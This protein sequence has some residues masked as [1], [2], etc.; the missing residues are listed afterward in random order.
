MTE[1]K[2]CPRFLYNIIIVLLSATLLPTISYLL[3]EGVIMYVVLVGILISRGKYVFYGSTLWLLIYIVILLSDLANPNRPSIY[4]LHSISFSFGFMFVWLSLLKILDAKQCCHLIKWIIIFI[5]IT[6]ISSFFIGLFRPNL[7]REISVYGDVLTSAIKSERNFYNLL[8]LMSYGF[9]HAVP[10]VIPALIALGKEQPSKYNVFNLIAVI[11]VLTLYI[12]GVSTAAFIG[13]FILIL[14][15]LINKKPNNRKLFWRVVFFTFIYVLLGDL[16]ITWV[17]EL[18]QPLFTNFLIGNKINS[19][20]D[21][22]N[23]MSDD[24]EL[25]YRQELH[26]LSW[27]TFVSNPFWGCNDWSI[28]KIGGHSFL[29]D[30]LAYRGLLGFLPFIILI[31]V[32]V[33]TQMMYINKSLYPYYLLSMTYFVILSYMKAT[34]AVEMFLFLFLIVPLFFRAITVTYYNRL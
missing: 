12:S 22:Y 18:I 24:N 2:S 9:G 25:L 30:N 8:G 13:T 20:L 10:L 29:M 28:S 23:G 1:I 14:S 33:K 21:F 31:F 3:P 19:I 16:I 7:L 26:D 32:H 5:S 4:D 27:N 11:V 6:T 17:L 34:P 15:M